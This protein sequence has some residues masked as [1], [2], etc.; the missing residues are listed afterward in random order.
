M[1]SL[2]HDILS[3]LSEDFVVQD[4]IWRD[5]Y[6]IVC[7]ALH[8]PSN[9][10]V[11]IKAIRPSGHGMLWLRALRELKLLRHFHHENIVSTLDVPKP[12]HEAS[13]V[14]YLI[15]EIM[16]TDMNKVISTQKLSDDHC[17]YLTYQVLRA[18]KAIHSAGI[19]HSGLTPSHL[20]LNSN[21]DLKVSGFGSARYAA[22][23][24]KSRDFI[25][26]GHIDSRWYRA[27]EVILSSGPYTKAIDLWSVGCILAEM[28]GGKPLFPGINYDDQLIRILDVIGTPTAEDY[29][30]IKSRHARETIRHLPLKGKTPWKTLL[31]G[32]SDPSLDLLERLLTFNPSKRASV[33]EALQ[34]PYF[35]TYHDVKDEPTA[36]PLP[37]GL[38][39]FERIA[40]NLS[41]AELRGMVAYYQ[42]Y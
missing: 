19:L 4:I 18:L 7:S 34:H 32:A 9:T 21:C 2:P 37:R 38:L 13:T 27:P 14:V 22:T 35:K 17:Q 24:E 29:S 6:V 28:L 1:S 15:Q 39:G 11:A 23:S 5:A 10:R 20:L 12:S 40:H 16:E 26:D 31:A 42:P 8:R 30:A 3:E 25:K 33:E 41:A 36:E